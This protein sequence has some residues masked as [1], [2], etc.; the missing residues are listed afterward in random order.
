MTVYPMEERQKARS[1]II[2]LTDLAGEAKRAQERGLIL[3]D[4]TLKGIVQLTG[5]SE[6]SRQV[7]ALTSP[8]DSLQ[9][10]HLDRLQPLAADEFNAF[11]EF[12]NPDE[13]PA[14]RWH[15]W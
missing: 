7:D 3:P 10:R 9:K 12:V 8:A 13:A 11:C 2:R 4:A 15:I 6:K 1:A 14:S 5:T